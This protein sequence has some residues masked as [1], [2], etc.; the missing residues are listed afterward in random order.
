MALGRRSHRFRARI[1]AAH[2]T[3]EQPGRR[4]DE[5]L[6]REIEL[7]AEPAAHR[8]GNDAD[9]VSRE[10]EHAGQL[11]AVHI[12]RLRAGENLDAISDAPGITGLGLDIGVLDEAG[13]ERAVDDRRGSGERGVD[14]AAPD[15]AGDQDIVGMRLMENRRAGRQRC[16]G[17]D[18]RLL[19]LP[20]DRDLP[21]AQR[22]DRRGVADQRQHRLA[23]KAHEAVGEHRL[24]LDVGIDAEAV[25]AGN[26]G[27]GQ[28]SDEARIF[29]MEGSEVTDGEARAGMR[30]ADGTQ[31]QRI[32]RC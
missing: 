28:D 6:G 11:V 29:G 18:D 12:G 23:A 3:I 10:T 25:G 14:I 26:I 19:R 2:G 9:L 30:R 1:D 17:A 13:F 32:A 5:R 21:V 31:E 16:C 8:R 20:D 4:G 27:G 22:L 7:A 15:A 24:I